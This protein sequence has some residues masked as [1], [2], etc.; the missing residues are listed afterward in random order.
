MSQ[1]PVF[2]EKGVMARKDTAAKGRKKSFMMNDTHSEEYILIY[3][4]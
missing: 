1:M 3:P 4:I 2:S